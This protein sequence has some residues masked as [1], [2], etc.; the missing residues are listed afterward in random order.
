MKTIRFGRLLMA[1]LALAGLALSGCKEGAND[2]SPVDL[3]A[4]VVQTHQIV[5]V[6]AAA[7]QVI[8]QVALTPIVKSTTAADTR[9]LDVRLRSYRVTYRRTDGGTLVPQPFTRTLNAVLP[10]D[11]TTAFTLSLPVPSQ[12]SAPNSLL[13]LD[14]GSV[15]QAPFVALRPS[16]GGV[17][18]ETGR[19]NV[20]LEATIDFFGET[21]SGEAVAA[22]TRMEYT[23]CVGC[24]ACGV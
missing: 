12:P 8:G 5:D 7:C 20:T 24:G 22:R 6:N 14:P 17:D 23:V 10:V 19:R 1:T 2:P 15:N 9:F 3:V 11:S 21:L 16:N 4:D 18:P 13:I